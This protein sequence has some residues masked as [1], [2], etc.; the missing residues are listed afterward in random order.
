MIASMVCKDTETTTFSI[1]IYNM[2]HALHWTLR[3]QG[4]NF[5]I[6][7]EAVFQSVLRQFHAIRD[8]SIQFTTLEENVAVKIY[9]QESFCN[10]LF[11]QGLH[12]GLSL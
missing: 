8:R 10:D 9:S 2:T 11:F 6:R 5:L 1:D 4:D 7:N 3:S 12:L